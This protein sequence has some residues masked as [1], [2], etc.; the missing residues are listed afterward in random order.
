[1]GYQMTSALVEIMRVT[2]IQIEEEHNRKSV[3]GTVYKHTNRYDV[4]LMISDRLVVMILFV[5]ELHMY[6]TLCFNQVATANAGNSTPVVLQLLVTP[7]ACFMPE[8]P[9]TCDR[10]S[11]VSLR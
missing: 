1:M 8:R 7:E 4:F 2:G 6:A 10:Q 3:L 9:V 5:R 11:M